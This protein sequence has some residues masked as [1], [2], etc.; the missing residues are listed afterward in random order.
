M[1]SETSRRFCCMLLLLSAVF[2]WRRI[3]ATTVSAASCSAGDVQNALNRATDGDIVTIPAGA[4]AWTT[5]V[6]WTAPA[7]VTVRGAGNALLGGG[8]QTIITDNYAGDGPILSITT[9]VSGTFRMTGL[10]FRG[11]STGGQVK[12]NGMVMIGGKSR[13]LRVDHV[14]FNM[15]AY[16][17]PNSGAALRFVGRIYGVVDH[18]LFDL[19]GVGNGIQI[20]YDDGSAGDVTW[21]EA[22]G[23]GSDALLFVE[24]TTFNA[25]SRFGA[26]NDCADGGKWVWRHNTLNSAMVQTHPTGGGARGRGC[27]AWEVYLNAFN[28]SN[29]APSFNAAFISSGTGVIWGN[30][31]SAG[32]SNFVTL[33]SMRKSNSTYTQTASPNGWGYCGTAFNGLGSNLDGNTST[34]TGYPC[35][36]QPGRGVGDLL[37]GAFPNVTNTAT[38]CAA[39]SPCAW[40]RQALEPIYEWANTWAAV[41][42]DG[43]SY[44]SVYEPTVLLQN[45]DYFLRASVFTGEAGTGVG[46]LAGRPSTCTAGV[47]YWATDSNTLF[48]CS[49]ANTWTV[50][51]RPYTYPH[52][53]TQDAQ[54]IPTAPQNVRIIR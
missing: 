50:Y 20:H 49:T 17:P 52:P 40:P 51:Y 32:Y 43:G 25:D 16:S 5:Q 47:G 27:R 45:Q 26:S 53:L 10:T 1:M 24:D 42:G 39:S 18:S 7:N 37:S 13:N 9:S 44:W 46:T 4:C 38:G 8:D 21:A 41:P 3:G 14:H 12:W 48:Q 28:G 35:L 31:A 19:S 15:Q 22:T 2:F 54:A 29:D 34:S 23:L 6:V 11:G 30:T 33:H 36:D